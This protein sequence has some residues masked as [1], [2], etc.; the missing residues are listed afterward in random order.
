[1][2]FF[3]SVFKDLPFIYCSPASEIFLGLTLILYS[4]HLSSFLKKMG[5]KHTKPRYAKF[6]ANSSLR[7]A[8]LEQ[9]YHVMS[10]KLFIF[11][12]E[13]T[14]EMGNVFLR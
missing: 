2:D 1:M 14:H 5:T 12:I 4:F 13:S 3:F 7:F 8:L 10:F 9:K 11:F 6:L